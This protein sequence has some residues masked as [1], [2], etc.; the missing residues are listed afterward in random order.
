M[1]VT[2]SPKAAPGSRF[3]GWHGACDGGGACAPAI[4]AAT[5][6]GLYSQRRP[7]PRCTATIPRGRAE[8][9]KDACPTRP[10]AS[11]RCW[12]GARPSTCSNGAD[13]RS[14][15]SATPR[16][17]QQKTLGVKGLKVVGRDLSAVMDLIDAGIEFHGDPCG[18]A[19]TIGKGARL[20]KSTVPSAAARCGGKASRQAAARRRGRRKRGTICS[21]PASITA[22]GCSDRPREGGEVAAGIR[23]V[24]G[25]LGEKVNLVGRVGKTNDADGTIE[26][27]SRP[28]HLPGWCGL[29]PR[30]HLGRR[31]GEEPSPTVGRAVAR[32]V[33]R[34]ARQ[35][36]R[37]GR[38]YAVR[39]A[40]IAPVQEFDKP[41]PILQA[42]R[43]TVQRVLRLEAGMRVAASPK[44]ANGKSGRY[45]LAIV[46]SSSEHAYSSPRDL[47]SN[48]QPVPLPVGGSAT[49]WSIRVY[50]RYQGSNC[51]R[52]RR[53]ASRTSARDDVGGQDVPCPVQ[54]I[55]TTKFK[56]RVLDR[57]VYGRAGYVKTIFP[58]ESSAP[59]TTKVEAIYPLHYT[60]QPSKVTFEGEGYKPGG[61][62]GPAR[63]D[64]AERDVCAL[65]GLVL[66]RAAPVHARHDRCRPLR[67]PALAA[68]RRNSERGT[69]PV[70]RRA[71][72]AGEGPAP[73]L[74][75]LVCLY[76]LPWKV[77]TGVETS[78][79]NGPGFSHNGTQL[80]AFDFKM[81]EGATTMRRAAA[82]SAISSSRTRRT[83]TRAPTTTATASRATKRT[84]KRTVR[85]TTSASTTTT[86]PTPTTRTFSTTASYPRRARSSSEATRSPRR[87]RRPLVWCAPP[88][89]GGDRQ[90]EQRSTDRRRRS[91]SRG[92][93]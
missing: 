82:W 53:R 19:A 31:T 48:D 62:P 56:A 86:T 54:T 3:A 11:S 9:A 57:G 49:L 12:K 80:Y 15:T 81:L 51:P 78:Q 65:A 87:Q 58:L 34:R 92:G 2:L 60:I 76:K 18:G 35:G 44:C 8:Q 93:C 59:Q 64:Q 67:R 20:L 46:M 52:R 85:P 10:M 30:R 27:Q 32:A 55:S 23:C 1:K 14:P 73:E 26:L 37:H 33:R 84:R 40:R 77:A 75:N 5:L 50:E 42:Q 83:S 16:L 63:D 41:N 88:L 72:E 4:S 36:P 7:G 25:D 68:N 6:V 17:A 61:S 24:C 21:S 69:V 39:L 13:G 28:A 71:A 43:A 29:R 66:R 38:S 70:H 91:A 47:D 79:G 90:V 89:P 22:K 45:S 74:P